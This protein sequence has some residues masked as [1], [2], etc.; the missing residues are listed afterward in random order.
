MCFCQSGLPTGRLA[1]G[2]TNTVKAFTVSW[3]VYHLVPASR[4]NGI[5]NLGA[6]GAGEEESLSIAACQGDCSAGVQAGAGAPEAAGVAYPYSVAY[7][8]VLPNLVG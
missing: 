1:G 6:P 3:M 5:C 2:L 4:K 7:P 8:L